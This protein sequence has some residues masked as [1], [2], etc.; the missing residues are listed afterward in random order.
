MIRV[1]LTSVLLTHAAEDPSENVGFVVGCGV[2]IMM[3]V[4]VATHENSVNL[5]IV[6]RLIKECPYIT[7]FLKG[8]FMF[9]F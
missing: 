7:W 2:P 9:I 6:I 1:D 8:N 4:N 3:F 5:S